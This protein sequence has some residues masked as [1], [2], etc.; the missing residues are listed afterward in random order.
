MT[1]LDAQLRNKTVDINK[2]RDEGK[3]PAVFYGKK[4]E[5]TPITIERKDFIKV[6]KTVGESGVVTIKAGTNSVDALIHAVD[7]DP[8]SDIPRHADFYVFEKGK[9]IE[10]DVPLDFVGVSPA[11]KDL[12]GSLVKTLHELK[13]SADPQHIPHDIKV[14]ISSLIDFSS[15]ILASEIVLPAGVVLVEL[16]HEVVASATAPKEDEPE[17][18]APVDLSAIEVEK[19]GKKEE[20][21]TPGE[22]PIAPETKEQAS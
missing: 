1:T 21:G 2:L 4:T 8:V 9:K 20:E 17:E 15:Q 7:V 14:D 3:M 12:G 19:K 22:T 6:W 10:V 13:I 5:S 16:P 18:V 11:I